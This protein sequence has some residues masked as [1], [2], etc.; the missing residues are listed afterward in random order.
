MLFLLI[1][2]NLTISL[3]ICVKELKVVIS[4]QYLSLKSVKLLIEN[5]LKKGFENKGLGFD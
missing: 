2:I 3:N 1:L 5:H 4:R